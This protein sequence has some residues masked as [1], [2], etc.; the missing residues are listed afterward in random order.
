[1]HDML[2]VSNAVFMHIKTLFHSLMAVHIIDKAPLM[3]WLLIIE[4]HPNHVNNLYESYPETLANNACS[5]QVGFAAF[6]KYF[7]GFGFI[8]PLRRI[9]SWLLSVSLDSMLSSQLGMTARYS[10]V[11]PE[12]AADSVNSSADSRP[13]PAGMPRAMR[14]SATGLLFNRSTM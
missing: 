9:L 5:R 7:P 10:F 3:H 6:Y 2:Y 8:L 12:S 13:P 14:V 11:L 4:L 1:M